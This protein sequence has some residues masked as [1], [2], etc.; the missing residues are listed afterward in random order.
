MTVVFDF[1]FHC[2]AVVCLCRAG[3]DIKL[4][5][6]KVEPVDAKIQSYGF[7]RQLQAFI[8]EN[9]A[10]KTTTSQNIGK[11]IDALSRPHDVT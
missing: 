9:P 8:V 10:R 11:T 2:A 1:R 4:H 6:D 3:N 5:V 7:T